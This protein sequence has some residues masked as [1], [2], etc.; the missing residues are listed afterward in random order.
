M[1]NHVL[2]VTSAVV[3]YNVSLMAIDV[4]V[5]AVISAVVIYNASLVSAVAVVSSA[6]VIFML[7]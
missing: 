7:L 2:V 6:G 4:I 3:I 1:V 5:A